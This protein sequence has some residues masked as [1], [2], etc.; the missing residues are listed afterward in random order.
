M[1]K[2]KLM[3]TVGDNLR[4]IRT[5]RGH[6]QEQLSEI[7]GI[8]TSFYANIERGKKGM[9]I[10]V[11]CDLAEALDVSADCIIREK[12]E[13]AEKHDVEVLLDGMPSALLTSVERLVRVCKDEFVSLYQEE[14]QIYATRGR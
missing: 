1:D 6:T 3:Q 14:E 8:S 2:Q 4:R 13:N 5:E 7:A 11:L 9:S 10:F 12:T